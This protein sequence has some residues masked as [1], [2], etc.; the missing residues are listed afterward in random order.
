MMAGPL[1]KGRTLARQLATPEH[2][3]CDAGHAAGTRMRDYGGFGDEASAATAL[4]IEAGQHWAAAT[5]VCTRD[6]VFRFLLLLEMISMAFS[7]AESS[8]LRSCWRL[9]KS[10]DF[11]EHSALKSE[12]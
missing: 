8:S 7:M 5:L 10:E 6:T 9:S 11:C 12:R 3:V 2:V 4:L 1:A